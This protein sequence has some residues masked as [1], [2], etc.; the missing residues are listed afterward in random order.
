MNLFKFSLKLK[1]FPIDWAIKQ[2][3]KIDGKGI[4]RRDNIIEWHKKS[5]QLYKNIIE[6][7]EINR[8]EDLPIMQKQNFQHPLEEMISDGY[9][10][11]DLFIS[12]TSGSSGHPFFFAKDKKSHALTHAII[13]S[14]YREIGL[15]NDDIQARFYGVPLSGKSKYIEK[16]KD[17][18]ANR[19]RFHVFD[20][21]DEQLHKYLEVF[22]KTKIGYVY[23]YTSAIVQ[24]AKY[25]IRQNI[26]LKDVCPSLKCCIVTS[27]VCLD[28]DKELIKQAFGVDVYNEYG[29]SESGLIAF[30][31]KS[32]QWQI[33]ENEN[34]VEIVD[35]NG[36]V[37]P[38][39]KEGRI[40][41]TSLSNK[42]MPI[43]RYQ[44]GDRGILEKVDGKLILK[45]L[46]GRVND[47]VKLPSGKQAAGLTF[48]YISRVILENNQS[49]REFVVRQTA[50]DTFYFDIVSEKELNEKD[51]CFLQKQLDEYLEPGLKLVVKR[52]DEIKRTASGKIKHFYSEI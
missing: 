23:G 16:S 17:V 1:G 30:E 47:M 35:D 39:G 6:G 19:I 45:K 51:I 13:L 28:D 10:L 12:S 33:V 15:S 32:H 48:Y 36:E 46:L 3:P 14:L 11:N 50:L 52:V 31:N 24:F 25:L 18:L 43:I 40:L 34:Y 8:F 5:N 38:Y 9:N 37:L 49:I 20:L 44:V 22:R 21:S 4:L 27:E 7:L 26:I 29:C 41:L 42:A 2:L